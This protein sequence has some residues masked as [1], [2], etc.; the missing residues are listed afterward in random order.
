MPSAKP[1]RRTSATAEVTNVS[2]HGIWLLV[3]GQEKFLSFEDFPWFRDAPISAVMKVE[4]PSV[5]HL[6]WPM[7]DVDLAE[8]SIDH[9]ETFP[10]MSRQRPNM[11]LKLT[12]SPEP[13]RKT[14]T[15]R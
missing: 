9:P 12:K 5:G 3:G 10:L 15:R 13:L 8:E 2:P 7:L 11:P 6:Y 14:R 1:G 4:R